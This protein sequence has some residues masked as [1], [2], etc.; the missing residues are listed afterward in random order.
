[1]Q[2]D[3]SVDIRNA[4]KKLFNYER[5]V[6]PQAAARSLNTTRRNVK[7]QAGR[8]INQITGLQIRRDI[9]PGFWEIKATKWR[10]STML[11]SRRRPFNLIRF[12]T[13]A[14]QHPGAFDKLPGVKAKAWRKLKIYEGAFIIR[15]RTH[16]RPIV[17]K[18]TTRRRYPI[19]GVFGPSL[20]VEFNRPAMKR[21]MSVLAKRRF[22]VNFRRDLRYYVS[23]VN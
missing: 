19:R 13:P 15:G 21:F 5:K 23:R 14:K 17:V 4:E 16:G 8:R 11:G 10:L 9:T 18:R 7:T 20:H 6:I 22:K 1:M 2:I 3:I 12:V